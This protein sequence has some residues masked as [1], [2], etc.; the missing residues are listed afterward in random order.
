MY[1]VCGVKSSQVCSFSSSY[2]GNCNTQLFY[3]PFLLNNNSHVRQTLFYSS[4]NLIYEVSPVLTLGFLCCIYTNN[5][6]NNFS[7]GPK[8]WSLKNV[9]YAWMSQNLLLISIIIRNRT[10]G[11]PTPVRNRTYFTSPWTENDS[12]YRARVGL[13]GKSFQRP[14]FSCVTGC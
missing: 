3:V 11:P 2:M 12:Y 13:V 9:L 8:V 5:A 6:S 10:G 7:R 1:F 14:T 4:Y